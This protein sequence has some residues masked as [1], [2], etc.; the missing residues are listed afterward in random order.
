M[1]YDQIELNQIVK[2][3][4]DPEA[5]LYVEE[6]QGCEGMVSAKDSPECVGVD[7]TLKDG[8]IDP[9]V[10]FKPSELEKVD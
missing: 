4:M 7:V 10:G 9:D 5:A 6:Y 2:I 1:E 3:N 8:T